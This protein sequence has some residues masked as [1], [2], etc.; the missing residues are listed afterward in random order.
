MINIKM[1]LFAAF[2]T[3]FFSCAENKPNDVLAN[4]KSDTVSMVNSK[5]LNT[6]IHYRD[7]LLQQYAGIKNFTISK[8]IT[9]SNSTVVIETTYS[10]DTLATS[11]S[12]KY[13]DGVSS[14]L[15][16]P[17]IIGQ[18]MIFKKGYDILKSYQIPFKKILRSNYKGDKIESLEQSIWLVF[19]VKGANGEIWGISGSGL[20]EVGNC[21]EFTGYYSLDGTI[22]YEATTEESVNANDRIFKKFGITNNMIKNG[23]DHGVR[24]DLFWARNK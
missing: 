6:P 17:V 13:D 23:M 16:R 1:M 12:S 9:I 18:K 21:P 22:L 3:I 10:N 24:I 19:N 4:E 14:I 7:S 8:A 20:C 15:T 5:E 11:D 2:M